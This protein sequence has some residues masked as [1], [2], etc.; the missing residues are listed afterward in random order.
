MKH[1]KYVVQI[2]AG[3]VLSFIIMCYRGLFS[4]TSTAE[5]V[6][7]V[8]DGFTIIAFLYLGIGSLL[9]LSTTGI[10]D[11]FGYAFKKGAHA[12]IPGRIDDKTGD[13]YEYKMDKITRRKKYTEWSALVVGAGFLLLVIILTIVWYQLV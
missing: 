8:C 5:I 11:I 9:W 4:S 7:I 3:V 12:I 1:M 13:Y 10:F 2:I 6:L